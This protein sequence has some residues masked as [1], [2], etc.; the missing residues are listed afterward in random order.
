MVRSIAFLF[1]IFALSA[2]TNAKQEL[3]SEE[4]RLS[5]MHLG[6]SISKDLQKVLMG[7]VAGAIQKGGTDYAVDFCHV[8]ATP[9]TDSVSSRYK[10]FIQR[11]SDKNRNPKNAITTQIDSL[12]WEKINL[13]KASFV[14]QDID[15]E[16]YYYKPILLAMSTC[17]KCHGGV[18]DI[19]ASTQKIINEKYPDDKAV[20]YKT[21]DLRG[22]WK[23]NITKSL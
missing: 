2:C 11:L 8:S 19:S 4:D 17:V 5:Y 10:V 20:G 18:D 23:V 21:G 16:I 15:G 3:M 12:A 13:E 6:D 22:M 1:I 9:L 7:E 14:E